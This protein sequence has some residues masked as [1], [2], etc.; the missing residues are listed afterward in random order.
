MSD[1]PHRWYKV[2]YCKD[3]RA[4]FRYQ[5]GVAWYDFGCAGSSNGVCQS[6][7]SDR[8][9]ASGTA[10]WTGNYIWPI[11]VLS[12]TWII[13]EDWFAAKQMLEFKEKL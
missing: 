10:G 12:G 3:C 6:C 2:E 4:V 7:G 5:T 8:G 13:R 9:S 1:S 11:S